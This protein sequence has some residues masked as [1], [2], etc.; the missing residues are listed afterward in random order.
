MPLPH[1]IGPLAAAI[2]FLAALAPPAHGATAA[3]LEAAYAA[4]AGA[5]A[6]PSRGQEFF[7]ARHGREWSCASCHGGMPTGT[8]RHAATGRAI[9]PLAPAVEARRFTDEARTEKWFRRNCRDVLGRECSAG[10]KADVVG[11]LRTLR[12]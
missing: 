10:E 11:W 7:N 6:D 3:S 2:A 9:A 8:G 1:P 5:P 4:Q 12:P